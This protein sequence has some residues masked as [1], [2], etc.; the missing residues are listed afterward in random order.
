MS[1]KAFFSKLGF[2]V[3]Q[4]DGSIYIDGYVFRSL[5]FSGEI[6][7]DPQLD[8]MCVDMLSPEF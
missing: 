5:K 6:L 3:S 8:L 4:V 7:S 2:P 1:T